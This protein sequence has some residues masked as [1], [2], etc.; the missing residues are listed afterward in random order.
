M[1][2]RVYIYIYAYICTYKLVFINV[3][4][5]IYIVKEMIDRKEIIN[6]EAIQLNI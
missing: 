2:L 5:D 4:H 3:V 6:Q 1:T